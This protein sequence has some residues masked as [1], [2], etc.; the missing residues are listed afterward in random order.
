MKLSG[1]DRRALVLGAGSLAVLLGYLLL[2]G[3]DVPQPVTASAG[4]IPMAEKRLSRLRQLAST[5][6]AREKNLARLAAEVAARDQGLIQAETPQQAQAQLLQIL[7]RLCR[8]QAPPLEVRGVELGAVQPLGDDYGEALVTIAFEARIE[9]LVN[10]LADLTAQPELLASHELR[11]NAADQKQKTLAV[12][13]T[14]SGMVARALVP[15]K[16]GLGVL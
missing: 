3:D 15:V 5:A 13:L 9:Q 4:S 10:L 8:A 14:V 6:A 11:V 16:K 7:R 2:T 1:R 12:R